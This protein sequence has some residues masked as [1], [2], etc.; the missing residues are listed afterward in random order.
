MPR[1]AVPLAVD[2]LSLFTKTL[3]QSLSQHDGLPSH[4]ELLNFIARAAGFANYQHLRADAEAADRLKAAAE[5]GTRANLDQV[6]KAARNFDK[7]G[8]LLSW[9]SRLALQTLSQWVFWSRIP[10]GEVFTERQISALIQGWHAFG[11][12]ALIRRAMVDARMLERNQDGREYRRIERTPPS[13]LGPL[14]EQLKAK[15]AS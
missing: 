15:A 8:V 13:E 3:R 10:R 14:L 11:D 4:V 2:D 7:E 6:E 9:P 1:T 5:A 12:H